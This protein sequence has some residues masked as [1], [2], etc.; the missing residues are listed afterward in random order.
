MKLSLL[1]TLLFI[2]LLA[3]P[4]AYS[5]M[6]EEEEKR[7][8]E[9]FQK[10]GILR[11]KAK[12]AAGKGWNPFKKDMAKA[13][14]LYE[15][16]NRTYP[17]VL[18]L[19]AYEDNFDL[20]PY[21]RIDK[22]DDLRGAN[23][24]WGNV[25]KLVQGMKMV[26]TSKTFGH[27]FIPAEEYLRHIYTV[28]ASKNIVGGDLQLAFD[29][30]RKVAQMQFSK[31]DYKEYVMSPAGGPSTKGVFYTA[32]YVAFLNEEKELIE[33]L[34]K[35][36]KEFGDDLYFDMGNIYL[37]ILNKDY[38]KAIAL[39]EELEKGNKAE[40]LTARYL[41][42]WTYALTKQTEKS[43]SY[44]KQLVKNL[45]I[46]DKMVS[47]MR[48]MN[49]LTNKNYELALQ[50]AN[51]ALKPMK[52]VHLSYEQPGK[53]FLYTLRAEAYIGLKQYDKAKADL[54]RAMLYHNA[55]QP[56]IDALAKLEG[57]S[58]EERRTDKIPPLITITD[59]VNRG[60]QIVTSGVDMLIRGTAT[61]PSG[62]KE[63][64]INDQLAYLQTENFWSNVTL[65]DGINKIKITATD[66]AGNI[67]EQ[68]FELEKKATVET[69]V[70]IVPVITKESKNYALLI[71]AQNYED[72][73]IPSLSNPVAD[74]IK[75]KQLFKSNYS[76]SDDNI[77]TLFNPT[78]LDV[79]KTFAEI[80]EIIQPD[81]NIVIFYAGHG[82][83]QESDKKGYWLMTDAKRNDVN[84]WFSNKLMLEL[85]AKLPSR[86]TLLITD[87]CFSGGVFKTRSLG[88]DAPQ[89]MRELSE[90][91]SRVAITSGNDTEVP[92]ESVFMKY[93]VKALSENKDKYLT[94]QKM[95]I[96]HIIEAVMN[97]TKTEPRY[98][99]LELAG[100]V[101]GDFIFVKK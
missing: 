74:A 53:F 76:F 31:K 72:D 2:F 87:A 55:Y 34:Q 66:K 62:I 36:F 54:E 10:A 11:R 97:E 50:L 90:K 30:V 8:K 64:K 22:K 47:R 89:A 49:A 46:T 3:G 1:R 56:A 35:K 99:T 7:A 43:E 95:F 16:A 13:E 92:D 48:A 42:S 23:K 21:L 5:Q 45:F 98:G 86:H 65:N 60:L 101:G 40:K 69:K 93:L 80:M 91:I 79:K 29:D 57:K 6:T 32:Q 39:A 9:N 12:E 52:W 41:L 24:E 84:T 14:Q 73:A 26:Y 83:W 51:D 67:A 77:F 100:H 75:L 71:A 88:T 59:P 68:F 4:S 96:N 25:I 70:D 38:D 58:V 27:H 63:V 37:A 82:M 94:A 20:L 33:L 78:T 19:S 18:M 17:A 81:D 85:I 44:A 15:E 61:D 28:R